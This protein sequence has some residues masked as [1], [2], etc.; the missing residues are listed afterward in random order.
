MVD[1]DLDLHAGEMLGLVGAN[2]AG[3]STLIKIICG[4]QGHDRGELVVG[5]VARRFRNVRDALASGIAVAHQH[6]AI[7]PQLT[8]AENIMLGREPLGSGLIRNRALMED[9]RRLASRFG[10]EI[11]LSRECAGLSLGENKIL[12]ILKALVAEPRILI[13]DE[14]TA[15]LTLNETRRLFAFLADLKKT[16]IGIIFISHHLGEVFAHCDRVAVLKDGR[17]VHDGPVAMLTPPALVRMMVGRTIDDTDWNSHA[18]RD[19]VGVRIRDMRFGALAVPEL[20]VHR[21]EVVG[22]A[23]VLGA[24]QTGLLESLAGSPPS[25][26]EGDAGGCFVNGRLGLPHRVEEAVGRGIY[27][28]A[29]ERLRKALFPG[30]SVEENLHTA[31]LGRIS[32]AGF[33]RRKEAQDLADATIARLDVRCAGRWQDIMQ[34]S[35]GNQ[36]KVAFGRWL[37]RMEQAQDGAAL[38]LLDNPTEGVDVG[39]KAELYALIRDMA[40]GGASI[41]VSS[42]EFAELITLC[43]RIYCISDHTL[44]RCL[45][46][47]EFSEDR[48]LL[49]VS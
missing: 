20:T 19:A 41:L 21:G 15:S 4:A 36:Q 25:R 32:R 27:L 40:R 11:D 9:A 34:L 14:P 28:I 35:G 1:V 13:L 29:D 12:D 23:G 8:A 42:A 10:V 33:V 49:E 26:P 47:D 18:T 24:G 5:G 6:L 38:F 2:G 30:L 45:A 39:S 44:G 46:R 37:L 43:D 17:K 7:I 22:V 3:K 31:S 48:L 16:G